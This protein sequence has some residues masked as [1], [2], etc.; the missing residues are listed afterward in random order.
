M[1]RK[2]SNAGSKTYWQGY[3]DGRIFALL[4]ATE[5]ILAIKAGTTYYDQDERYRRGF[6]NALDQLC[7]ELNDLIK[8]D[9][10][11]H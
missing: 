2:S 7:K 4:Y 6:D 10:M 1:T 3:R 11:H 9:G 8:L 5:H